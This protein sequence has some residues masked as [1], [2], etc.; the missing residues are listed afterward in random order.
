MMENAPQPNVEEPVSRD[1]AEHYTWGENCEGWS[2]VR[3]AR[4]ERD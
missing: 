2:L 3:N 1:N 4:S